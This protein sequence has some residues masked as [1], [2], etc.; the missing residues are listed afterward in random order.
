[1]EN[2]TQAMYEVSLDE[3][4]EG[5]IALGEIGDEVTT[6]QQLTGDPEL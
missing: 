6:E 1:M 3:D 5:G 4:D 2:I